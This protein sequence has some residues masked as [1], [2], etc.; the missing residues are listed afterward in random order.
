[1]IKK[2]NRP[3]WPSKQL[4]IYIMIPKFLILLVACQSGLMGLA[5]NRASNY[6]L[7]GS[8]SLRHRRLCCGA[9]PLSQHNH[10]FKRQMRARK[11]SKWHRACRAKRGCFCQLFG[12][13]LGEDGINHSRILP[14]KGGGL[15]E[16]S[17]EKV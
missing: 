10:F 12:K 7:R 2:E 13:K 16:F 11:A 17:C 15:N 14:A 5:D 8:E 6:L 9:E 3:E 1:M 4:P